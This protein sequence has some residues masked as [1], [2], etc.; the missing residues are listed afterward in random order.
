MSLHSTTRFSVDDLPPTNKKAKCSTKTLSE[1]YDIT[2]GTTYDFKDKFIDNYTKFLVIRNNN[3][4]CSPSDKIDEMWH[5]H[6][7]DTSSYYNYCMNHFGKIIN[8]TTVDANNQENRKMR[9]KNTIQLFKTN[10]N[11]DVDKD[12]WQFYECCVCYDDKYEY[13]MCDKKCLC[14]IKRICHKCAK[15]IN[16]CPICRK[17]YGITLTIKTILGNSFTIDEIDGNNTVYQLK[18][19]IETITKIQIEKQRLL[20]SGAGLL[21]V[22]TLFDYG[23][24]NETVIHL[25]MRIQ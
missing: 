19:Q 16:A 4:L 14:K 13:E 18:Q 17:T 21:D 9:L 11:E 22:A 6:I 24:K 1:I 5:N 25:I 15:K 2:F 12:I 23:I 10:Y 3:P 20:F 7:L 8:H